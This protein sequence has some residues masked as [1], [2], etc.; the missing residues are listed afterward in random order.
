MYEKLQFK[1]GP[2]VFAHDEYS[3]ITCMHVKKCVSVSSRD[4]FK[5][6]YSIQQCT[7][8]EHL[9]HDFLLGFIFPMSCL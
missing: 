2:N 1:N 7:D 8:D 5:P 9:M 6:E 4:G 3:V